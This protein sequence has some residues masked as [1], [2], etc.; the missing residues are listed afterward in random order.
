MSVKKLYI[1]VF[2]VFVWHVNAQQSFTISVKTYGTCFF[3][4]VKINV[5]G[6]K[7]PYTLSWNT[8]AVGDTLSNLSGGDFLVHISDSDTTTRDTSVSFS[9]VYPPCRVSFSNHFTPNGDGINDTWGVSN[10]IYYPD[11]LLEVFD[12]AGQLV[13]TQRHEYFHWDGTQFGIKLSEATYYY[14]FFY[15]E[16]IKSRFEKGS[17]TIVR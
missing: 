8:G 1:F 7:P 10:T 3:N 4:S 13:H 2:S 9:L 14:I 15:D 16:K 17:V 11:F 6:N 12:R 5:T